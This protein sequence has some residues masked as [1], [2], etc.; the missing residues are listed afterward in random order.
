MAIGRGPCKPHNPIRVAALKHIATPY[1]V[2]T[3]HYRFIRGVST[4]TIV[5]QS[6]GLVYRSDNEKKS[7][8]PLV[9]NKRNQQ[10][11]M[12]CIDL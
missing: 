11:Y 4:L 10:Y 7:D 12:S 1:G 3:A 9:S 6:C 2:D 8:E 5:C